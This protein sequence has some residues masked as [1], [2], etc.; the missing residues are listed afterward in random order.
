MT[1]EEQQII[2]NMIRGEIINY[3]HNIAEVLRI[4]VQR[5]ETR[6]SQ[7]LHRRVVTYMMEAMDGCLS[8]LDQ[9]EKNTIKNLPGHRRRVKDFQTEASQ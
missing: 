9:R 7:N 3:D 5:A 2:L 4:E 6:M 1:P 8:K